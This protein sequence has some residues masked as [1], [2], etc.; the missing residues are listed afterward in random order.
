MLNG[1]V[2]ESLA[3]PLFPGQY[4]Q[5]GGAAQSGNPIGEVQYLEGTA[6]ATRTDGTVV[7]LSTGTEVYLGD[8]VETGASTKFGLSL[9]DGSL[10][11]MTSDARM[12]LNEF[13]FN[14]D[15]VQDSSMLVNIVQGAFVFV[16][17]SI[18]PTGNMKVETPVAVLAIRGTTVGAEVNSDLGSTELSLFQDIDS[19]HVGQYLVLDKS[20]GEIIGKVTD[21][22]S[23]LIITGIGETPDRGRKD[24]PGHGQRPGCAGV[25]PGCLC[26]GPRRSR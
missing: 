8:V 7:E 13:V 4:A 6:T 17:G 19:S 15:Q 10:F 5:S 25:D 3:G 23:K 12:V 22:G 24:G 2:V 18:A 26:Q 9:A 16:A 11:S 21:V 14:A 20:T 1:T